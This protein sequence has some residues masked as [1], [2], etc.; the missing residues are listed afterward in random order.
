MAFE[1]CEGSNWY[2]AL[3]FNVMNVFFSILKY[4]QHVTVK[5]ITA[6]RLLDIIPRSKGRKSARTQVLAASLSWFMLRS[7]CVWIVL[8]VRL[9]SV[10]LLS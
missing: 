10:L 3:S 1:A 2:G 5:H 9:I 4:K 7:H 6:T 8:L